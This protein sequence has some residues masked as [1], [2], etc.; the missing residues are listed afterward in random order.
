MSVNLMVSMPLDFISFETA[1]EALAKP[2][3]ISDLGKDFGGI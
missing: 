3:S 1:S 2:R